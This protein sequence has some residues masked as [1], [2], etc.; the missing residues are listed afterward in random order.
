MCGQ[1]EVWQS[2]YPG[3]RI[4][5]FLRDYCFALFSRLQSADWLI[6]KRRAAMLWLP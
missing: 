2:P 4:G 6:P 1:Y 5:A 3:N